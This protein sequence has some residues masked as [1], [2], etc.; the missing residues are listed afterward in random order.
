ADDVVFTIERQRDPA[1]GSPRRADVAAVVR[2]TA[3][4]SFTVEVKLNRTGI[5][6]LNAL[7]EVVPVP[8]HL[9]EDVAPAQTANAP[10]SRNPV[11]NGFY[12]FG[13]WR[14]NQ[15]LVLYADTAK[16]DGRAAIERIVM[17]FVPDVNSAMAEL[18]TG[19]ADLIYKLPPSQLQRA[20]SS[21]TIRVYNG[22]RVRPAWIA[23]NTRRP[24]LDDVRVRRALLMGIDRET[25]VQGMF[26]GV[27]EALLSPIP[28]SL[29]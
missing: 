29:R 18:L 24:P 2:A 28:A 27:G 5:Y 11:G 19:S 17:R 1:T 7:L 10:F 13:E 23:W 8:K 3:V 26:A 15:Q 4:D 22:P 14:P 6:T 21:R 12:R 16:P 25:L 20:R 9:L